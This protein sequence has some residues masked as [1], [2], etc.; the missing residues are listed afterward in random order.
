MGFF[1]GFWIL[2]F[3]LWVYVSSFLK[4][5]E[6]VSNVRCMCENTS[7][8]YSQHSAAGAV[9]LQ[10]EGLPAMCSSITQSGAEP[11]SADTLPGGWSLM[12]LVCLPSGQCHRAINSH[13]GKHQRLADQ[14]LIQQ[15][16]LTKFG[17][18]SLSYLPPV[19]HSKREHLLLE[20]PPNLCKIGHAVCFLVP[21]SRATLSSVGLSCSRWFLPS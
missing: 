10:A 9:V 2:S 5:P 3:F 1:N 8:R 14:T 21:E 16:F 13:L 7:V 15:V 4:Q 17:V 20:S 11:R 12:F 18:L 19:I 6:I